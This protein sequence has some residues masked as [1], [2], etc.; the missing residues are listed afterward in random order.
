MHGFAAVVV[1]FQP[2]HKVQE[3]LNKHLLMCGSLGETA[4]PGLSGKDSYLPLCL[5]TRSRNSDER[6]W[7]GGPD[8]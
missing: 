2:I 4:F 8:G 1:C 5:S 7:L 6:L 3:K